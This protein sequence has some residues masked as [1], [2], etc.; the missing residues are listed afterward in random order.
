MKRALGFLLSDEQPLGDHFDGGKGKRVPSAILIFVEISYALDSS[1]RNMFS[2]LIVKYPT[3]I[4]CFPPRISTNTRN[5][6]KA[7]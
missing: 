3:H 6:T 5:R 1:F 2:A 4:A 7:T